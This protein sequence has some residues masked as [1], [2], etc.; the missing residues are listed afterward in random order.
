MASPV[1]VHPEFGTIHW[2]N[3]A[4]LDSDVVY[5]RITETPTP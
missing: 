2:P 3:G 1:K 5:A 4:D